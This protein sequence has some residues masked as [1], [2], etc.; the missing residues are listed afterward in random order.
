MNIHSLLN[1]LH[2]ENND[3]QNTKTLGP[4]VASHSTQHDA[5]LQP[6][7]VAKDAPIFSDA[8]KIAGIVNYP[9]HESDDSRDLAIQHDRFQLYP[10]GEIYKK[11]VRHIPYNSDKKDF[12]E[13]TG[14]EAFESKSSIH[15]HLYDNAD[16][17]K[18]FQ[19]TF[20]VPGDE[21][22][23]TVVWDYNIGL[24]RMT[25]FFKSCKYSKVSSIPT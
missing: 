21:K 18:V 10:R 7:K 22:T 6:T 14:R 9:P 20:K 17:P 25:P 16:H 3:R 24:V 4:A 8:N 15:A 2:G 12:L 13:K 19:Y 5:S 1:P 23:Y 11:G